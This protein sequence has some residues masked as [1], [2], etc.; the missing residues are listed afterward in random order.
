MFTAPLRGL[1]YFRFTAV[2]GRDKKNVGVRL[3]LNDRK[4]L[5]ND[6]YMDGTRVSMSNALAVE[7]QKGDVVQMKLPSG[8]GVYDSSGKLTTFTGFLLFPM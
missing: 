7:L 1:Y 8:D 3:Y 6:L 2:D 4:M 5:H